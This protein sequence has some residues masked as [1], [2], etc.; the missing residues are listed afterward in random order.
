MIGLKAPQL[1][2]PTWMIAI[3]LAGAVL[4]AILGRR[5]ETR[6]YVGPKWHE[7]QHK[8]NFVTFDLSEDN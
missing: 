2:I 8:R 1:D 5:M 4:L 3:F 6:R 7:E